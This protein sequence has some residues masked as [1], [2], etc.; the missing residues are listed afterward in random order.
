MI[1][2][3][4]ALRVLVTLALAALTLS[5]VIGLARP[6]TGLVEKVVLVFLIVGCVFLAAKAATLSTRVQ[7]RLRRL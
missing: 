5:L 1:I 3:V 4:R 2:L 7:A 6:E